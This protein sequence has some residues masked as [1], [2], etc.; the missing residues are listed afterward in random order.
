MLRKRKA[1]AIAKTFP[2]WP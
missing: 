1:W 2:T